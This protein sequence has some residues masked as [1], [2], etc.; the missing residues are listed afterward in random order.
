[1]A[2]NA[3]RKRHI[4]RIGIFYAAADYEPPG[5]LLQE[6][7]SKNTDEVTRND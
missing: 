4:N 7:A 1:M 6:T 3:T 5:G 2:R